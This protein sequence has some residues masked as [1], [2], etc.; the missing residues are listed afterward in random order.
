MTDKWGST[1]DRLLAAYS[2]D[3]TCRA[4]AKD[5]VKRK[6]ATGYLW[7]YQGCFRPYMLPYYGALRAELDTLARQIKE[8]REAA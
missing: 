4:L 3:K 2:P 5:I 1:R 7:V 6:R 8:R